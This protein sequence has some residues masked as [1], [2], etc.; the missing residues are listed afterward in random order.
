MLSLEI[1]GGTRLEQT[2]TAEAVTFAFNQL[3]PRIKNCTLNVYLVSSDTPM[4][5]MWSTQWIDGRC[6]ETRH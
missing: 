1:M 6:F 4:F 3:I 2:L 5:Q